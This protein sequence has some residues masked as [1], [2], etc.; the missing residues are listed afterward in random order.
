MSLFSQ[1]K[2]DPQCILFGREETLPEENN[3]FFFTDSLSLFVMDQTVMPER[4]LIT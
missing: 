1:W 2:T 3:P 4:F